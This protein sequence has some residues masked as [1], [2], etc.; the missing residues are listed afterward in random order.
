[1]THRVIIHCGL[2]KTGTTA[3]QHFL[4][5]VTPGL[6]VMQVLVPQTGRLV[7]WGGGHHNI[8]WELNR[9][10]R[11]DIKLGGIATLAEEIAAFE[12]DT[13]LSSE[14][15]ETCLA[16][17]SRFA[18]LL[19]HPRL[20]GRQFIIVAYLRDQ[21]SYAEGLFTENIGHGFADECVP[22]L[23]EILS[24]GE[25]LMREW[26]F[27]F[28]YQRLLDAAAAIAPAQLVLRPY[29]PPS[30]GGVIN[31]FMGLFFPQ[32]RFQAAP[33]S[34]TTANERWAFYSALGMFHGNR[35]N[36]EPDDRELYL[37]RQ[38]ADF[39]GTAPIV[40]PPWL[41]RAFVDRFAA[42]NQ[43]VWEAL[44][45]APARLDLAAIAPR[46]PPEAVYLDRVYSFE[47]SQVLANLVEG[48]PESANRNTAD[49]ALL[50]PQAL[51]VLRALQASWRVERRLF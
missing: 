37:V 16:T 32:I 2:H 39:V 33:D 48:L 15:F 49:P 28:D 21:I 18:P 17:P 11:F 19:R 14:D 20:A 40:L 12:G 46:L 1:M 26:R 5:A 7:K 34:P 51:M 36:R 9:D 23:E 31:D 3:L 44:G 22:T 8:A 25:W 13:I 47:T 29:C 42:G 30:D 35:V 45:L 10:R 38:M 24:R 27:Q 50:S 41:R 4:T 6:R 43:A